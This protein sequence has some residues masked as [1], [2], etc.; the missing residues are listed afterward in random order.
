MEASSEGGCAGGGEAAGGGAA[1]GVRA[2]V[3]WRLHHSSASGYGTGLGEAI[4][5]DGEAP[6]FSAGSSSS[7]S[8][9]EAPRY[10]ILDWQPEAFRDDQVAAALRGAAYC[11]R[12][13]LEADGAS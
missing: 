3:H 6:V 12:D 7:S 1:A 2:E 9:Q 4:D 8:S 5:P 10:L 11:S 13:L